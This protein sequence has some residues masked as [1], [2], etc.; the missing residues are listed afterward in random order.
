MKRVG[1]KKVLVA[2]IAALF[3]NGASFAEDDFDTDFEFDDSFDELEFDDFDAGESDDEVSNWYDEISLEVN[4]NMSVSK[5]ADWDLTANKTSS[6]AGWSGSISPLVYVELEGQLDWYWGDT[7]A[8]DGEDYDTTINAAFVQSSLGNVSAKAGYFTIGWGEVEGSGTLDVINPTASVTSGSVDITGKAQPF[9]AADWYAGAVTVTGFV[10]LAP[11]VAELPGFEL[12]KTDEMEWGVKVRTSLSGSDISLYTAHLVP[13]T[14]VPDLLAL[15]VQATPYTLV[16]LSANKSIGKVLAKVDVAYK[17]GLE[18]I[19]M[20]SATLLNTI[21]RLDYA[22]GLEVGFSDAKQ[23]VI[24][25]MNKQALNYKSS[26]QVAP[27]F[28]L[29]ENAAQ[30]MVTLS[31]SYLNEDLNINLGGMGSLDG[32]LLMA[33]GQVTYKLNDNWELSTGALAAVADEDSVFAAFNKEV[34]LSAGV[35]WQN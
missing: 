5:L 4:H 25:V 3:L 16:G 19:D 26:Y 29:K 18:T 34:Q 8:E 24:S 13:N 2:T 6:I 1:L 23:L 28:K 9:V 35:S 10:N 21:N 14:P 27:G 7:Q 31:D 20:G 15:N 11:E 12:E 30:A 33:F 22:A 32:E 17:S